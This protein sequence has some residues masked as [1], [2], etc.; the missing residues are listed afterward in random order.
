MARLSAS[1]SDPE[2]LV[3]PTG[4]TS[5]LT[6]FAAAAMAFLT[7]FAMALL[8]AT[9][10][11]A[12][13]WSDELAQTAT[14]RVSAP[15]S[16]VDVQVQAVL[17]ILDQTP[18]VASSRALTAEE[19]QDL[20]TPWFGVDLPLETLPI[21][22]LIEVNETAAGI[23][24]E[25]LRLRLRAEVPGAVFDDHTRWRRPLIEAADRLRAL[26]WV[27]LSLIGLTMAAVV[28]LA[29]NASLS[30]NGEVI[31]VLRL[32]GARDSFV[33][34]A[35]VRRFTL[36]AAA[37]A[38]LGTL[39]AMSAIALFPDPEAGTGFLTG[40]RFVG[41]DWF[42]PLLVPFVAAAVAFWATRF[43][44]SRKLRETR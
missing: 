25:G 2:G 1:F 21:P 28:T 8:F 6:V 32:I 14:V 11:V 36:R 38:A 22:Q 39:A 5:Q 13:R 9:N 15:P 24:A 31:K 37:G 4:I 26:G 16:Q 18:G 33:V 44:A 23:D 35:F 41:L 27:S 30:A 19:K 43:A 20:L 17:D 10:R 12:E 40:I 29:A 7:V 34:K 42:I 3:P